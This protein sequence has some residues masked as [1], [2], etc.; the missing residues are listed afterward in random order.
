MGERNWNSHRSWEDLTQKIS[1][2]SFVTNFPDYVSARDLW[3]TCK[4]YGTVVDVFIPYKKS[5]AENVKLMIPKKIK[6]NV[7]ISSDSFKGNV[8]NYSNSFA[9]VLKSGK[10][11]I[12]A[13]GWEV[14][15][16][17]LDDTC[18]LDRDFNLSHNT[19]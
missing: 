19:P 17:V 3:G 9:S 7:R 8:G 11:V 12:E 5:K 16:L 18:F 10:P 4:A 14:P 6:R 13:T 2:L 1:K 15:S